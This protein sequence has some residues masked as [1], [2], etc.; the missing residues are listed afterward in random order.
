VSVIKKIKSSQDRLRRRLRI[1]ICE[2]RAMLHGGHEHIELDSLLS[3][4][5]AT[6]DQGTVVVGISLGELIGQSAGSAGDFIGDGLEDAIIGAPGADPSTLAAA[7]SVYLVF[8]SASLATSTD[9]SSL[10]GTI[11]FKLSGD[12]QSYPMLKAFIVNTTGRLSGGVS[13]QNGSYVT[14]TAQVNFTSVIVDDTSVSA[15]TSG[16]PFQLIGPFPGNPGSV[17]DQARTVK[18]PRTPVESTGTKTSTTLGATGVW[19]GGMAI[20]NWSDGQSYNNQRV[21]NRNAVH[22]EG[23]GLASNGGHPPPTGD[24]HTQAMN[25]GLM[26]DLGDNG[27][28][29]SKLLGWAYDGFPIYGPSGYANADG[30]GGVIKQSS[31]W[32]TR[33]ITVRTHLGNGTDVADGPA[34]SASFPLGA[35]VEDFEFQQCLGT[36]DRYNGRFSVTPEYPN[37]IYHYVVT[38]KSTSDE[39]TVANASFPYVIGLQYYGVVET[40]NIIVG[41][42]PGG[43]PPTPVVI[44]PA[45]ANVSVAFANDFNG[46]GIDD[47]LVGD[48]DAYVSG[49]GVVGTVDVVFGKSSFLADTRLSTLNGVNGFDIRG[50]SHQ[51]R[52]GRSVAALNFNGDLVSD[53]VIGAS[54]AATTQSKSFVLLA[55]APAG[56][57]VAETEGSTSVSEQGTSDTFSVVLDTEPASNVVINVSSSRTSEAVVDKTVLIFTPTNWNILKVVTV[58][59]GNDTVAD[60]SQVALVSLAIDASLSNDA[61]DGLATKSV[62]VTVADDDA[63]T[64]AVQNGVLITNG[65][66]YDDQLMVRDLSSVFFVQMIAKL[67]AGPLVISRTISKN[68]VNSVELRRSRSKGVVPTSNSYNITPNE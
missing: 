2:E 5:G 15:T 50:P 19:I 20:Y 11:G 45:A 34:V 40:A 51:D 26:R 1:E 63:P 56:F 3:A 60:G 37:G 17:R 41:G 58:T 53:L 66:G 47:T 44:V 7:G 14:L 39:M 55:S 43:P 22:W 25:I 42:G 35:N 31:S 64:A 4:N 9:V 61:F 13:G 29:H 12:Y 23:G 8:G 52:T 21:W 27:S 57:S 30:T 46:D 10:D 24:Y 38:L 54:G 18:L 36:L 62:S 33:D 32:K 67:P 48:P 49:K 68:V 6:G 59:G 28:G 16:I 65:T